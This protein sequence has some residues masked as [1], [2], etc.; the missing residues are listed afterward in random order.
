MQNKF[1]VEFG[2]QNGRNFA[3][4]S[5]SQRV[6]GR[7]SLSEMYSRQGGGPSPSG[8]MAAMPDVPGACLDVD[9]GEKTYKLWDPLAEPEAVERLDQIKGVMKNAGLLGASQN[10]KAFKPIERKDLTDDQLITLIDE[11][12]RMERSNQLKVKRGKL[13][14]V[15]ECAKHPGRVLNDLWNTSAHKPKYKDEQEAYAKKIAEVRT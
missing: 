4:G 13:P 7:F 3:V 15:E 5:L 9:C 2:D 8:A 11:M 14:T 6:R 10:L 12:R 1:T